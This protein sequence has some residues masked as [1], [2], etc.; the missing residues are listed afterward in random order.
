M[1]INKNRQSPLAGALAF[2][3]IEL[4]STTFFRAIR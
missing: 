4:Y 3:A 2:V 1:T